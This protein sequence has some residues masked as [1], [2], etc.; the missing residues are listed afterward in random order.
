MAM[1]IFSLLSKVHNNVVIDHVIPPGHGRETTVRGINATDTEG[2][3]GR[4]HVL[5]Q[6][7][8]PNVSPNIF[9]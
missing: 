9:E 6:R 8:L 7:P 1:F 5:G 3:S 2:E 4:Y